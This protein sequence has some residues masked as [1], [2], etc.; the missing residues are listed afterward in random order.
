M[1]LQNL[2]TAVATTGR[3]PGRFVINHAPSPRAAVRLRCHCVTAF[4]ASLAACGF[5]SPAPENFR[6]LNTTAQYQNLPLHHQSN[7]SSVM[8]YPLP[9]LELLAALRE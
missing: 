7:G 8:A 1:T 2:P 4:T 3:R 5:V 6:F 9:A